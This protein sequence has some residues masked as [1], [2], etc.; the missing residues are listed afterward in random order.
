M[1]DYSPGVDYSGVRV[2]IAPVGELREFYRTGD[3][4]EFVLWV[5]NPTRT[6]WVGRIALSWTLGESNWQEASTVRVPAGR[7]VQV[8]VQK[9][10]LGSTGRVECHLPIDRSAQAFLD[11]AP[12]VGLKVARSS[13][14]AV[15]CSFDVRDRAGVQREEAA[16]RAAFVRFLV[17]LALAGVAAACGVALLLLRVR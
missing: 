3:E 1:A 13:T 17:L 2:R 15:L 4:P 5:A 16:A 12:E 9:R 6:E 10:W 11:M 14:F 7:T 8:P